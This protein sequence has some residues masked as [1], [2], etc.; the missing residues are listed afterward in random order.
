MWI[1]VA[2]DV[3][4]AFRSLDRSRRSASSRQLTVGP[5]LGSSNLSNRTSRASLASRNSLN[6]SQART[7][8][9]MLEVPGVQTGPRLEPTASF[10]SSVAR[11]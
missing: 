6:Q 2:K 1:N 11:L 8:N 9:L 10:T 7:R 3:F 4:E 5:R